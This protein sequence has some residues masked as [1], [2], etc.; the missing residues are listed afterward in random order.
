MRKRTIAWT[1]FLI[2]ALTSLVTGCSSQDSEGFA[3]VCQKVSERGEDVT[4]GRNSKLATSWQ[5]LRGAAGDSALDSRVAVRLQW[6][7]GLTDAEIRVSIASPGV[8]KL[9]G[10]VTN[11][12]QRGRALELA[13]AT[14]GVTDAVDAMEVSSKDGS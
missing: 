7:K 10:K 5:A 8:V 4:G 12:V 13:K 9:Q 1:P 3:K 6:D 2:L 11:Q 14:Q